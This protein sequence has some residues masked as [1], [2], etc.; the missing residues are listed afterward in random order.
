M[1]YIVN[2]KYYYNNLDLAISKAKAILRDRAD[3]PI[4]DNFKVTVGK[5]GGYCVTLL[6]SWEKVGN[7]NLLRVTIQTVNLEDNC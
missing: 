3:E 1:L 6:D 4:N 7:S 5:K 2:R